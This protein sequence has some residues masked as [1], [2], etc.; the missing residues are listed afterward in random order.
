MKVQQV[1]IGQLWRSTETNEAWL[2][3]KTYAEF[4]TYYA[5]L[6]KVDGGDADVRRVRVVN[7]PEGP[8]LAGFTMVE[9]SA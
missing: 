9:D 8:A 3:T 1:Q 5:V 7:S 2:V 4:F 6:R